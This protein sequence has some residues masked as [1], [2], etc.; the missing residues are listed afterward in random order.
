VVLVGTVRKVHAG[1]IHAGIEQ[2][3]QRLL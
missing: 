3:G 2:R 1:D